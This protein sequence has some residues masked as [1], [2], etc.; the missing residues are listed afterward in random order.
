MPKL[1]F[2][3]AGLLFILLAGMT[4]PLPGA[5]ERA[6]PDA[7]DE[8]EGDFGLT[9]VWKIHLHVTSENWKALQPARGGFPGFGPPPPGGPPNPGQP[10][11]GPPNAGR[12]NGERKPGDAAPAPQAQLAPNSPRP[13]TGPGAGPGGPGPGG[14]GPGFRPGSFGYEFEYVK[15]DV[16]LDGQLL[17]DV[18]LRFKG[19]GTYMMSASGKKRPYKIDFN[20]F[21]E[22]QRFHGMQQLNL[23]NNV[24]DPTHVRQALS[25]PVFQAAGIPSPRTAFAEVRLTIDGE[26]DHEL[27]GIYTVVEDVGKKFLRRHYQ[28]SKGM[29]LKP[30][31]TQGLEYKGEEWDAYAWFEPQSKPDNAESQ[32]LI[33]TVRLIHKSDD[34]QFRREI[35]EYLDT[36]EVARFLAANALLSNMDS[37]L[38]HVHNY[39]V[40]LPPSTKKFVLLPW[41]LDLSMGAFFMAG[42]PE[43]LQELSI[44]HPH[45]GDNKLLDRLMAWD[46]FQQL[47]RKHLKEL[48]ETCFG[49]DGIT[50]KSL[51]VVREAIKDL[52]AADAKQAAENREKE[53]ARNPGGNGPGRF[54]P[55]GFGPGA[56]MFGTPESIDAFLKKRRQS[57]IAQL[58]GTSKGR[59]PGMSFGPGSFLGPQLLTAGDSDKD[60]KF[61]RAELVSLAETWRQKWDAD[62]SDSLNGDEIKNG[63]NEA[64]APPANSGGPKPP[65][66]FGPGNFL[67][68][69][70]LRTADTDKDSS[71][72]IKEWEAMF[73]TWMKDWDANDDE[74][75]DG[76]ELTDGLNK[77]FAPPPGAG[78]P[79]FGPPGAGPGPAQK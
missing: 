2:G 43:Q 20:R 16:E 32:R 70:L 66:G 13:G 6:A 78:P 71:A 17:K 21:V 49:A 25:Y 1:S 54:G 12:P 4:G 51:P 15:A 53:L 34:E 57:V 39:Y 22:D 65:A 55:P 77:L 31:G 33:D 18:G 75:L 8:T 35:G 76:S 74:S 24:M 67:G 59:L 73:T 37:F 50:T 56:G 11:A 62:K 23:H 48:N 30:K 79:G 72:S 40:Y 44:V 64:L 58:E 46:A 19:N 5:E 10:N 60:Q 38:T 3:V 27:L 29:L 9:R 41:D 47:Y 63:L 52:V 28:T 69:V 45:M 26:S 68:P 42:S 61:S 36:D 7:K 14:P